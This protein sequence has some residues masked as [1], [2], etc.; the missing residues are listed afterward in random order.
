MC[1]DIV[2]S[3]NTK[4]ASCMSI[5]FSSWNFQCFLFK[6]LSYTKFN[7]ANYCEVLLIFF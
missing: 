1:L 4:D 6:I 7:V 5:F 3:S 2:I